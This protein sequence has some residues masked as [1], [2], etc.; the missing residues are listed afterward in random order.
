[1]SNDLN[2]H[3]GDRGHQ[4]KHKKQENPEDLPILEYRLVPADQAYTGHASDEINLIESVKTIWDNRSV[5]YKFVVVGA[6]LGI[7]IAL[8]GTKEYV[9]TSTLMPEYNADGQS[10]TNDLLRKYGG[11]IGLSGG[12]YNS[13]SN[14]IRV[15]LYPQIVQSL[16]FQDNLARQPFYFSKYD[17]T[18]SIYKYFIDIKSPGVLGYIKKFTIGLPGTIIGTFKAEDEPTSISTDDNEIIQLSVAEMRVID[19]LRQ[20]VTASLNSNTGVVSVS[21]KMPDP[22]LA[23]NVVK[24]TVREL[25][26][27]LTEYRT[28]KVQRDLE[29]V[30]EQLSKA[31]TR[32]NKAQL[33]LADFR[34]SNKGSLTNKALTEQQQLQSEFDISFNLYDGLSQQFEMAKLKVQEETPVFKVLQP[35]QVPV[36]DETSGMKIL[37]AFVIMSGFTSIGW[38]F[39]RQFLATNPFKREE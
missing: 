13:A 2:K 28:E 9:S 17:T 5:I 24:Y 22:K 4:P 16:S 19:G 35:I 12:S 25:T 3:H 20:R 1:M 21:A 7:L 29:F 36:D 23:A 26:N 31:E 10:G 14:A 30:K 8:L 37:I 15:D 34:D 11:L 18:V 32:F 33:A 27:Y 39:I 6:V 38:I